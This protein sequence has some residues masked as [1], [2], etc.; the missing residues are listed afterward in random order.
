VHPDDVTL[1]VGGGSTVALGRY[2]YGWGP[3]TFVM[4][5]PTDSIVVGRF[6]SIAE[7]AV[8]F[9]GSEH[10]VDQ[11]TTYPLRTLLLRPEASGNWDAWS[12]GATRI[13]SDVWLGHRSTVM[14]GVRVGHGAIVGA[15]AVVT[16][17]VPDYAV[18]AGNP[19]TVVRRRFEPELVE[20]LVRIAWWDWDVERIRDAEAYL[21]T[22]PELFADAAEAGI[23]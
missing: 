18:V 6:T 8:V 17:D 13:G 11:V 2:T 20:R 23:V 5:Q 15:G 9:G 16:R 7:G 21:T 10:I 19:A 14:S 12:R 22:A 3:A 4:S 1:A